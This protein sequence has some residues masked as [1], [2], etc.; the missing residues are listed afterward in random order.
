V[1]PLYC[2]AGTCLHAVCLLCEN[3]YAYDRNYRMNMQMQ[4]AARGASQ[5][6]AT[7]KADRASLLADIAALKNRLH[8]TEDKVKLF[9]AACYY[10]VSNTSVYYLDG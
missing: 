3:A 5:E 9:D 10:F 8:A 6:T 4:T 1:S 2:A 7:W